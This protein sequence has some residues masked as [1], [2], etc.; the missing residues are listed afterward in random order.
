M[1]AA[2]SPRVVLAYRSLEAGRFAE[3][4]NQFRQ[5]LLLQPADPA[6]LSG[7]GMTLLRQDKKPEARPFLERAAA[8]LPKDA[9]SAANLGALLIELGD[10]AAAEGHLRRATRL[11]P[12]LAAAWNNLGRVLMHLDRLDEAETVLRKGLS[13]APD[14]AQ[15]RDNWRQTQDV[16]LHRLEEAGRYDE[17]VA[18]ASKALTLDPHW[19]RIRYFRA[20]NLLR[21]R[22]FAEGWRDYQTTYDDVETLPYPR[23]DGTSLP[24]GRSLL[25]RAE[26]GIGEQVMFARL[27]L[28][29]QTVC[30]QVVAECDKRMV[31]L[32][33]RS[34]PHVRW[35]PWTQP[36]DPAL[37]DPTIAAQIPL[38]QIPG[39]FDPF[40]DGGPVLVPDAARLAHFKSRFGGDKPLVGLSWASGRSPAAQR[41]AVPAAS[42]RP[43]LER[44]D[45]RFV[46]LQYEPM[47][48][49]VAILRS[50]GAEVVLSDID[51]MVDLDGFAALTAACDHVV[52]ISNAAAHFA[53]AL[54]VETSLLLSPY[55][56]WHWF[57]QGDDCPWYASVTAWRQQRGT[58]WED[59]LDQ[60]AA[61]LADTL[62][63]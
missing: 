43:L 27:P 42:L 35:V 60:L 31:A 24:P 14:Y 17:A 32:M 6:A 11:A 15:C 30:P 1:P 62:N 26:Q 28:A 63:P 23:W 40:G 49:D 34:A 51:P 25:I 54:G 61:R 50:C 4:E 5:A 2:P 45:A 33:K 46:V 48:E 55:P 19:Q 8:A 57:A 29:A 9:G 58:N 12:S 13:L 41:K 47:A 56:L 16:R 59:L 39:L 18:E 10:H 37:R 44:V 52:T 3:A 22:R 21:L 38:G 20:C 7:M 53:G 36:A